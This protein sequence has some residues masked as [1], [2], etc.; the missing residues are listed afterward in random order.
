MLDTT[1]EQWDLLQGKLKPTYHLLKKDEVLFTPVGH[2][3]IEKTSA[4][5]MIY[6]ARKSVLF[7]GIEAITEYAQCVALA[8]KDGKNT[9]KMV[10]V[11][12]ALKAATGSDQKQSQ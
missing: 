4:S 1:V 7:K 6:G 8:Q 9:E 12:D 3:V 10:Q 11:Q 2:M 5:T